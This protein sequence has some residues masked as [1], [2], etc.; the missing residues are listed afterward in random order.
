MELPEIHLIG[1]SL[2]AKTMN[3]NGKSG[4]DCGNLWQKFEKE[5]YPG[6]IPNKLSEDIVAVYHQYDGDHTHPFS[7]FI[8]CKVANGTITPEGLDT[9]VISKGLFQKIIASGKMP[10]CVASSWNE[11]WNSDIPR[12]YQA[13]YEVYDGRSKDWSNAEVDIFI[14]IQ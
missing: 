6:K 9:L 11:I 10:D 7:Y 14:S 1:L 12:A 3:E 4:V 8:G 5:N 2:P 13:D